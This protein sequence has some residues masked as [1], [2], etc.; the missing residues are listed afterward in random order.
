MEIRPPK[1]EHFILRIAIFLLIGLP[2]SARAEEPTLARLSFRVAPERMAAF[3]EVYAS[4][5][6]PLLERRGLVESVERGRATPDSMFSRLF[7][8][9]TPSLVEAKGK[10]LGGDPEWQGLLRELG[11]SFAGN[12]NSIWM[13]WEIYRTPA[14][15]GTLIEAGP[16]FRQ[17]LWQTFD[18]RD[19]LL[20]GGGGGILQDRAGNLWFARAGVTRY[21]GEIF[22]T[23]TTENG[24]VDDAM[25]AIM[26]D[27]AGNLWFGT[28][29]GGVSRYDGAMFETFSSVDGLAGNRVEC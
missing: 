3:E 23:F 8:A 18:A 4:R 28:E 19:G 27:Q 22:T 14:G 20:T 17:G 1:P 21:D 29:E 12:E 13:R 10:E 24:L 6:V 26:E 16:G 9:G 25:L 7:E 2:F 15:S 5:V 11:D